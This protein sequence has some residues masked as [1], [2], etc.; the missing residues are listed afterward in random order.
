M[1]RIEVGVKSHSKVIHIVTNLQHLR[2]ESEASRPVFRSRCSARSPISKPFCGMGSHISRNLPLSVMKHAKKYDATSS[3]L[4]PSVPSAESSL[5]PSKRGSGSGSLCMAMLWH[6]RNQARRTKQ[7]M[8]QSNCPTFNF[9]TALLLRRY[10]T[11]GAQIFSVL[12]PWFCRRRCTARRDD[13]SHSDRELRY[14]SYLVCAA[15]I[16]LAHVL[17]LPQYRCIFHR[18]EQN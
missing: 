16:F 2:Y 4:L 1:C 11:G 8:R 15:L 13:P 18:P 14:P 6:N 17:T 12:L 7:S 10:G 5:T 3:D 9:W